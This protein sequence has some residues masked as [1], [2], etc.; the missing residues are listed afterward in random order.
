MLIT[1][2]S[3]FLTALAVVATSVAIPAPA[4]QQV[5]AC[6]LGLG[7]T[8][9]APKN[10]H[11]GPFDIRVIPTTAVTPSVPL[12]YDPAD[13]SSYLLL[14]GKATT[15]NLTNNLLTAVLH[16][17]KNQ[18]QEHVD[19]ELQFSEQQQ[20]VG[21]EAVDT[22]TAKNFTFSVA[23]FGQGASVNLEGGENGLSL[24]IANGGSG[25]FVGAFCIVPTGPSRTKSMSNFPV[26]LSFA[27]SLKGALVRR[28]YYKSFRP[29]PDAY[30]DGSIMS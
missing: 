3:G 7:V 10:T 15:F 21:N 19:V 2:S 5:D 13:K 8:V 14:G 17:K 16:G 30:P 12:G 27:D 28:H 24:G 9:G 20:C 6:G 11:N 29:R 26:S 23:E 22:L 18:A 25:L 1:S 4:P